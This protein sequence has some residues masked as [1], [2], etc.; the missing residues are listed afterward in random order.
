[1][2]DVADENS[3]GNFLFLEMAF[4]TEGVVSLI[5]HP[6]VDRSMR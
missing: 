3:A 1:M 6:L 4:E 2:I 5:E